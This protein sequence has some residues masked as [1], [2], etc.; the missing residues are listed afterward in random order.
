MKNYRLAK[1]SA[2]R[3]TITKEDK[4]LIGLDESKEDIQ[5]HKIANPLRNRHF[6][7]NIED[8]SNRLTIGKNAAIY[9]L[10]NS[11]FL[12]LPKSCRKYLFI[13]NI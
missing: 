4:D 10:G 5:E 6:V 9:G 1:L 12:L 2:I 8:I 13:F 3:G 7:S 11:N